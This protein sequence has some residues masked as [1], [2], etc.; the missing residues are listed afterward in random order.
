MDEPLQPDIVPEV[1]V[2]VGSE[3]KLYLLD[4]LT[5]LVRLP[6]KNE[7]LVLLNTCEVIIE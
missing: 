3:T 1:L 2:Y 7:P 5:S 4:T 6:F